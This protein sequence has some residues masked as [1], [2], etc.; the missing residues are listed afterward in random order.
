VHQVKCSPYRRVNTVDHQ[1]HH[2][3][4][5]HQRDHLSAISFYLCSYYNWSA[6]RVLLH[7]SIIY[8]TCVCRLF[9]Y[10]F[11]CSFEPLFPYRKRE[12][13]CNDATLMF[14][15]L[16]PDQY[17]YL[18]DNL[19]YV[20]CFLLPPLVV[21]LQPHTHPHTQI[22]N[23][24]SSARLCFGYSQRDHVKQCMLIVA[25]VPYTYSH[26]VYFVSGVCVIVFDPMNVN[27]IYSRILFRCPNRMHIC[28]HS[29][30]THRLSTSILSNIMQCEHGTVSSTIS[31][32]CTTTTWYSNCT[33]GM[34]I[35]IHTFMLI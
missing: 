19:L 13:S 20:I 16:T 1:W 30:T 34:Y 24:L 25:N 15:N 21:C 14:R 29:E 4:N 23:R 32:Q 11:C 17:T 8:G 10:C 5:R 12:F 7:Y 22:M 6:S 26:D 18:S 2:R 31:I 33:T 35:I 3:H 27:F 28:G 9:N